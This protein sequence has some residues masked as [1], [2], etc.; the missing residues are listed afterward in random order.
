VSALT[1]APKFH[2]II[3]LVD[4]ISTVLEQNGKINKRALYYSLLHHFPNG[5]Q[6]MD[7][8]IFEACQ[9]IGNVPRGYLSI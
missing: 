3:V 5:Q 6:E 1:N 8:C 4:Y 9:V 7:E 2:K